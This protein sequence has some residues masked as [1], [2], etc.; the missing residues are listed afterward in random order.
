MSSCRLR[1]KYI[2]KWLFVESDSTKEKQ[3]YCQI[4]IAEESKNKILAALLAS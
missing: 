2:A 1:F 4:K 3:F